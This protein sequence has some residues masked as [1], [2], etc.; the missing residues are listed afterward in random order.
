MLL[1]Y[2]LSYYTLLYYVFY[3][4]FLNVTVMLM[5]F[6]LVLCIRNI[7]I[8]CVL[9]NVFNCHS[10]VNDVSVSIMYKKLCFTYCL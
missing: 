9:L 10:Y 6:Q 8:L 2:I 5:M 4:M 1:Y 3:L 7:I